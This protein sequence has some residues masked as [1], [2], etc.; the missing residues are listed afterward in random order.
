MSPEHDKH[1][2]E[3][4]PVLYGDRHKS[5]RETCMCWGFTCDDGW[6]KLIDELS[7]KLE[8]MNKEGANIVAGQV[9]EKFGGLRF[10]VGAAPEEAHKLIEAA[11]S[12]SYKTCEFCGEPG[13]VR[14]GGWIK[15]RCDRCQYEFESSLTKMYI[16][17]KDTVQNYKNEPEPLPVGYAAASI[18]H[19]SLACYLKF[20]DHPDVI[21][22]LDHSFK[23]VVCKVSPE[24]FEQAK[25]EEPDHVVMTESMLAKQEI[26]LAFRPKVHWPD[27]FRGLP[28]YK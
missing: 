8:A 23:K 5:M 21:R 27:F 16:L 15:T 25:K 18:A 24:Q 10:Y 6:F 2:C 11:E 12:A 9:K 3:S 26:A 7:A 22:W 14:Q 4:Y 17:V 19:A 13:E 1:L 20:K 28:F